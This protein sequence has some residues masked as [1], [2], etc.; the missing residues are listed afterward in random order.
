MG[1][2]GLELLCRDLF[3]PK[4]ANT[5]KLVSAAG[6]PRLLES[7]ADSWREKHGLRARAPQGGQW[8]PAK[9]QSTCRTCVFLL[10][11]GRFSIM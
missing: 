2:L 4:G 3:L 1:R 9:E 10:S 5:L 8:A 7:A 11:P 6:G